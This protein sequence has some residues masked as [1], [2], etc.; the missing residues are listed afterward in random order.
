MLNPGKHKKKKSLRASNIELHSRDISVSAD[1]KKIHSRDSD[2]LYPLRIEKVINGSPTG[3]RCAFMMSKFIAGNGV[4]ES[5]DIAVNKKGET[6]NDLID[7]ASIDMAY[8]YGVYF[9]QTY[10]LDIENSTNGLSFKRAGTKVLD[11]V[12]MARSKEDDDGF[13]GKFYFLDQEEG[14]DSFAKANDKT[15][16]YY[17]YNP[18]PKIIIAQMQNDCKL[19]KIKDPATSQLI[20]NYRGQVLYLNLTPKF[21]YAL[22]L[23]DVV[24]DDMDTEHRI[25]RY[26]N[27]E[28]RRGWLGKTIITKFE[29][30]QQEDERA[31]DSFDHTIKENMGADNAANVLVI[32][33]PTHVDDVTKAFN[34]QQVKAQFDDKLFQTTTGNIRR[35]IM[36]AFNNIPEILV[37]AG[38][39]ALFGPNSETYKEAKKFYWE[40][41]E[42]ERFKLEKTLEKLLGFTIDILPLDG[43][44]DQNIDEDQKLRKES[45]AQLKGSVGGVTALLEIQKS[46]SEGITDINAAVEVIKEIFGIAEQTARKMLGTPKKK[47]NEQ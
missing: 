12:P 38:T 25:S 18:D 7:S 30:D 6:V 36:G 16:W 32:S 40:Q 5:T 11:Y 15:T 9:H 17:P 33:V 41:N 42:T 47:G 4:D 8:H 27:N 46:V 43:V 20:Q 31:E 14:T 34:V 10:K 29:D 45:Q 23:A 39:G 28:S 24:Y 19:R 35:N 37:S 3:K 21:V 22:P 44:E 2:N 26:T 1:D 13:P